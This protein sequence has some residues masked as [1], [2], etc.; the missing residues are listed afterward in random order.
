[1]V[2]VLG[3]PDQFFCKRT[4]AWGVLMI[5]QVSVAPST[6]GEVTGKGPPV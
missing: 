5:V 1:M 4:V 3:R 6:A 2:V